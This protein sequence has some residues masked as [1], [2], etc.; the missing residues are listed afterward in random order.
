M[1]ALITALI[2][3]A[4][5][6]PALA[7]KAPEPLK[8]IDAERFYQGR[9]FEIGR[10]PMWITDGCVAGTTDYSPGEGGKVAVKDA[11]REG[12]TAG[13]EKSIKG[14]GTIL[15][16]GTNAKLRVRYNLLISRDYWVFDRADDYSWFI[17]GDPSFKDLY[18]FTRDGTVPE[19]QRSDLIARAKALGY[20]VGK[21]EFPAQP[22]R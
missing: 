2:L 5:A 8:P 16:P 3:T 22:P 4:F 10:R 17:S 14:Q 18:I 15:D 6:G 12:V 7:A 20:D 1:R 11:C 21:L 9:W 19:A 13:K